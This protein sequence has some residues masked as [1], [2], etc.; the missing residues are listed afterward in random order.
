MILVSLE[1]TISAV[2][3]KICAITAAI[4][5]YK[6]KIIKQLYCQQ[7]IKLNKI[8]FLISKA[9]I[10]YNEFISI[11]NV[12]KEYYETNEEIKHPIHVN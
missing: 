11:N 2:R 3:L 7:K 1:I 5:K 4:K 8:K 12:L 10:D 9:L 6:W